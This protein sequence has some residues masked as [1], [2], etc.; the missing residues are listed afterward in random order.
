VTSQRWPSTVDKTTLKT[1]RN[2]QAP[3]E[4]RINNPTVRCTSTI[5][6]TRHSPKTIR[7]GYVVSIGIKSLKF[8]GSL[9]PPPSENSRKL[10][11][12]VGTY[13]PI[14]ATLYSRRPTSSLKPVRTT[15]ERYTFLH[16]SH[17]PYE[18]LRT[19]RY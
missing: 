19:P 1:R 12:N 8:W 15:N 9:V 2:I 4:I 7:M 14:S 17:L 13:L 11:R 5:I 18:L 6:K 3:C 10:L 16:W